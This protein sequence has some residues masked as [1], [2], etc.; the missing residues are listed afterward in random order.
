MNLTPREIEIFNTAQNIASWAIEQNWGDDWVI[1]DIACRKAYDNVLKENQE[2]KLKML[3]LK[4]II[5][6]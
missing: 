6:E 2:L 5:N 1:G 4:E 3:K